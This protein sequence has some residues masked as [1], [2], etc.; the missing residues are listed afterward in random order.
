MSR[1]TSFYGREAEL[2]RF[3]ALLQS[4]KVSERLWL[5][6]GQG[7][8]GKTTLLA[9]FQRVCHARGVPYV[10]L[11]ARDE[12]AG[13]GEAVLKALCERGEGL[14]GLQALVRG[15]VWPVLKELEGYSGPL[16]GLL[17]ALKT[18]L[19]DLFK[20][21]APEVPT[22]LGQLLKVV[23]GLLFSAQIQRIR[24]LQDRLKHDPERTLLENLACQGQKRR[25]VLLLDTF[26]HALQPD[27]RRIK[28]VL[29]L[30]MATGS[31]E[32]ATRV[33]P[34]E[35]TAERFLAGLIQV[36][37]QRGWLVV[38]AGRRLGRMQAQQ[39]A[40]TLPGLDVATLEQQ[41]LPALLKPYSVTVAAGALSVLARQVHRASFGGVPL[42]LNA[43]RAVLDA[44]L[45]EGAD[46]AALQQGELL[47]RLLAQQ[48]LGQVQTRADEVRCKADILEV[49]FRGEKLDMAQA[50]RL[51]LPLRLSRQRVKALFAQE[52]QGAALFQR[53]LDLGLCI[54]ASAAGQF[55][56][57]HEDVRD[58]LL[59]WG[60]QHELDNTPATRA[61]HRALLKVLEQE[62][63]DLVD[64]DLVNHGNKESPIWVERKFI[65]PV[66]VLWGR[67]AV[68]HA[69]FGSDRLDEIGICNRE[70][71]GDL[72]GSIGL[73]VGLKWR[74]SKSLEILPSSQVKSLVRDLRKGFSNEIK[75]WEQ[76]FG[77]T[78]VLHL[79]DAAK[80]GEI[81]PGEDL[82]AP[83]HWWQSTLSALNFHPGAVCGL[84][85]AIPF[86]HFK[87][88]GVGVDDVL[89]IKEKM[90]GNVTQNH[91]DEVLLV[92][93]L[94][95]I[96]QKLKEFGDFYQEIAVYD[97]VVSRVKGT[98]ESA[99]QQQVIIALI[100]KAMALW[101][102]DEP[103]Q[104]IA[105]Y[106]EVIR[107]F[108]GDKAPTIQENVAVA[109]VNKAVALGVLNEPCQE[110]AVYD[111]VIRLFEEAQEPD[112]R[113]MVKKA[114]INKAITLWQIDDFDQVVMVFGEMSSRFDKLQ[115]QEILLQVPMI[116]KSKGVALLIEAKKTT[117][118]LAQKA[119]WQ[120]AEHLFQ[121]A[122]AHNDEPAIVLGNLGYV[123][124]L[125]GHPEQAQT[126]LMQALTLGGEHLYLATLDN[127]A[128]HPLPADATM[129]QLLEACWQSVQATHSATP[130]TPP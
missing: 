113:E 43:L 129:R 36:L 75:G 25:A 93:A 27:A 88:A 87:Q 71:W 69:V 70:F 7:G 94:L 120:A 72:S 63:P 117:D 122:L 130:L 121:Q 85:G 79:R 114:L 104:A 37:T 50:W 17:D 62:R 90:L 82:V 99:I 39:A 58:L 105:M 2:A 45:Q 3:D 48:P 35:E 11:D 124:H 6:C 84:F 101:K 10:R 98:Q 64:F 52:E 33:Q 77:K 73:M 61:D 59:W 26:E 103:H 31:G 118:S 38:V 54:D 8:I 19:P 125:L 22:V 20:G 55:K 16:T 65:T 42:W 111:E 106:D 100:T 56:S 110:I 12:L 96:G 47:E 92:R 66:D 32:L 5:I 68:A 76:L 83:L 15:E 112:I 57:L 80:K 29:D 74:V 53:V 23:T 34:H 89:H 95:Q 97:E 18:A 13:E 49:L 115:V 4:A 116:Q 86:E 128:Q 44:Q 123:H 107:R 127:I 21:T 40:H 46:M 78:V 67:E 9:Q 51:A 109:L 28:S 119:A 102:L 1:H 81:C 126:Y 60:Q 91:E 108:G 30:E 24:T 14:A 41:W